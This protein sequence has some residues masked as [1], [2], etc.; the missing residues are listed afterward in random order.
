[1]SIKQDKQEDGDTDCKLCLRD[2]P[3]RCC[4]WSVQGCWMV[5]SGDRGSSAG[6]RQSPYVRV[7]P[8]ALRSAAFAPQT[9]DSTRHTSPPHSCE[10]KTKGSQTKKNDL[11]PRWSRGSV[12]GFGRLTSGQRCVAGT[13]S[14]TKGNVVEEGTEPHIETTAA[15]TTH[16]GG[17][18]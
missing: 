15:S 2:P 1:M 11:R 7:W 18:E 12:T 6:W 8:P 14:G 16:R 17:G 4:S 5:A 13:V 3:G 9:S 10:G